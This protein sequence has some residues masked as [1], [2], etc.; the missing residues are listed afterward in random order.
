MASGPTALSTAW[1][2][3]CTP[4]ALYAF[5]DGTT[6]AADSGSASRSE[7]T[8]IKAQIDPCVSRSEKTVIKAHIA[9]YAS[10]SEKTVTSQIL[11][12]FAY[13]EQVNKRTCHVHKESHP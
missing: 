11:A 10:R 13:G 9:P 8:V 3:K 1:R 7:K 4:A 2:M 6:T 12:A 5:S